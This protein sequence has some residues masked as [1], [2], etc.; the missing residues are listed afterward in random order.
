MADTLLTI[1]AGRVISTPLRNSRY[2]FGTDVI[3]ICGQ[4]QELA[5]WGHAPSLTIP[6]YEPLYAKLLATSLRMDPRWKRKWAHKT[7]HYPNFPNWTSAAERSW[8]SSQAT[9]QNWASSMKT[10]HTS[11]AQSCGP[12]RL[13]LSIGLAL[14][15]KI[16]EHSWRVRNLRTN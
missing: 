2:R 3:E 5:I 6:P 7:R 9:L 4:N 15:I 14:W 8:M 10:V 1:S 13:Q 12:V 16:S 11:S